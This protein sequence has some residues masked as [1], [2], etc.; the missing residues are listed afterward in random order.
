VYVCVCAC[1]VSLGQWVPFLDSL[2][3]IATFAELTN[4]TTVYQ[5]DI[6]KE[7]CTYG[8]AR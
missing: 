2:E 6:D 1:C 8:K 7:E 4:A 3:L 5:G